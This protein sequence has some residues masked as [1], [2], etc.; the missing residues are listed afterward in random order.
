MKTE[1]KNRVQKLFE[2]QREARKEYAKIDEQ[3]NDLQQ[4]T[5]YTDKYKAEII[6][7]LKQEKEQGL[8]AIDTMFNKQLKEIITEERKAIIG[9]PEAKPADYQIQ[10]SNALKFIETIGK[11]L[12]DKQLS[13][14]LEPFKNDMQTMQ[15]FK[16][17]VE[18]IFPET[19][20]I[21]RADGKGE[22]FKDILSSHFQ[23]PFQKTFGKVM[24][25]TAMLNNLDEVESL[26]GSL[27]DSKE[28]MKSGIKM[29]IF[30]SK[31]DTIHELA[32]AL[33]A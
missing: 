23:Y 8:K 18:G 4:S 31:V 25:Y 9:E 22:G 3:I 19:R 6:K 15:L 12:T 14:M 29:E 32:N 1:I 20:G 21:T 28:D 5:I 16:Q 17:V 30:N 2:M 26:A 33:E 13:E 11:S 27:F 24:D 7:Q 10:V